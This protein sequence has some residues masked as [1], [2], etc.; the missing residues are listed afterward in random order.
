MT[1]IREIARKA[2]VSPAT[3]SRVLSQDKT[4]SIKDSTRQ[5]VLAVANKLHY[6]PRPNRL[7]ININNKKRKIIVLCA[8]S[9]EQ[10]NRDLYFSNINRGLQEEALAN[11]YEISSFI[12]FPKPD[13]IF[14]NVKNF[15]GVIIIGTFTASFIKR[16]SLYNSNIVIIDEYRHFDKFDLI[17]NTYS[18]FTNRILNLLQERNETNIGFIGGYINEMNQTHLSRKSNLDPRT[19][20]YE[21]WMKLHNLPIKE[22]LTNWT[23]EEGFSAMKQLLSIENP[24]KVVIIASDVLAV[25][26]YRAIHL[27]QK[28]IP[29]DIEVVSYNNSEVASYLVPSLSSISAPSFEMGQAAIRL[30]HDRFVNH[31]TIPYHL[32]LPSKFIER[33]SSAKT[34][35]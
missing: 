14:S 29:A 16:V 15:D 25:G 9:I 6:D 31:R 3:V 11:H 13:F 19:Q 21:T 12:H 23:L 33:E 30:L 35:K 18:D 7:L 1:S 4:F 34:K 24:P 5:K 2:G 10:L 26:A 27:S 17:R 28:Q 32:L 8:L 20:A 22:V